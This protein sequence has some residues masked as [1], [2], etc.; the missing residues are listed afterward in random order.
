MW[1]G[2]DWKPMYGNAPPVVSS[3]IDAVTDE[4]NTSGRSGMH[5]ILTHPG[6]QS[7]RPLQIYLAVTLFLVFSLLLALLDGEIN[8]NL[9]LSSSVKGRKGWG[10]LDFC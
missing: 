9:V 6:G 7:T 3:R 5:E 1:R 10:Y 8:K 4:I 2:K